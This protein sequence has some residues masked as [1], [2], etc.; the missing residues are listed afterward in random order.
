VRSGGG[1]MQL[2][3]IMEAGPINTDT[4]IVLIEGR[5]SL[6]Q[7]SGRAAGLPLVGRS[8]VAEKSFERA[9]R[10]F[11]EELHNVGSQRSWTRG[12]GAYTDTSDAVY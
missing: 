10:Q 9:Y 4:R 1:D 7:G 2:E 3:F 12:A 8:K 6:A 11:E 5:R